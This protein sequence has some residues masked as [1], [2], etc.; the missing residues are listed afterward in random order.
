MVG[1]EQSFAE[2][3]HSGDASLL[4]V[5]LCFLDVSAITKT[6]LR[7]AGTP[8]KCWNELGEVGEVLPSQSGV[9]PSL[10]AI[11][12]CEVKLDEAISALVTTSVLHVNANSGDLSLPIQTRD[13]ILRRLDNGTQTYWRSQALLLICH[14][15]PRDK[16]LEPR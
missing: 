13:S 15:F 12:C 4:L 9:S 1:R 3:S 5:L 11:I 6:V 16:Y 2:M 7:R 10:L 8:R 14:G